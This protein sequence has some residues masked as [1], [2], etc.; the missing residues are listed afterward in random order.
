MGAPR[1]V[2]LVLLVVP[3]LAFNLVALAVYLPRMVATAWDS[4]QLQFDAIR[5]AVEDVDVLIILVG[6]VQTLA[7]L[8]PIA[9]ICLTL[10]S[11]GRRLIK[12][13]SDRPAI[14]TA[15]AL[16]VA[17][18][19]VWA[20]LPDGDYRSLAQ[21]E[22]LRV[23]DI[24][25]A[26]VTG[27]ATRS[28][29]AAAPDSN[30]PPVTTPPTDP[31]SRPG[32]ASAVSGRPVSPDGDPPAGGSPA[33]APSGGDEP[34]APPADAP[35]APPAPAAP[36]A[37]APGVTVPPVT[38]PAVTLPAVTAP[39]LT[40]PPVTTPAVTLPPVTAPDLTE[41][42]VTAPEVTL[43][44]TTPELTLPVTAPETTPSVTTPEV[45]GPVEATVTLPG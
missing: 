37:P 28:V 2:R 4:A 15:A 45:T 17:C 39:D 31:S 14:R 36:G 23:Q 11:V 7:L 42:P 3:I 38:A 13:T 16:V 27:D 21:G 34:V 29:P 19:C 1:R 35:D 44:V 40:A 22:R 33:P 12:K 30:A 8:I 6:V 20:L 32:E 43:P 5:Q 25:A 24:A 9:G 41:P 10:W 18:I 26:V